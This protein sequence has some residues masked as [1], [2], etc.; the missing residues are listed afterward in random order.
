MSL[1]K[2]ADVIIFFAAAKSIPTVALT[3]TRANFSGLVRATSS[4]SIPPATDAMTR[5]VR[6]ERSKRIAK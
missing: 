5:N 2:A 1:G 3:G 6:L 4:M